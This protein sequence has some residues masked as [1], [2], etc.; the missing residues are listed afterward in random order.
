MQK[1]MMAAGL[2]M[3]LGLLTAASAAGQCA[4]HI[5]EHP[6]GKAAMFRPHT[7]AF[8]HCTVS[9]E[10]YRRITADWLQGRPADAPPIN[11]LCLGRAEHYPWITTYLAAAALG[12]RQWDARHGKPRNID[13]NKLVA[14]IL[15]EPPFLARLDAAFTDS[16]ITAVRVWI[17]KVLVDKAARV[18]PDPAAAH[19]RVPIDAIVWIGL[20]ARR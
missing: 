14:S 9:E 6:E 12:H 18:L 4:P 5:Q 11:S 3:L 13:V 10:A 16:P 15:S 8:L 20:A 17:E 2:L 19:Q 7:T 1:K